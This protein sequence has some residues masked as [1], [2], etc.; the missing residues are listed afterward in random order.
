M[1]SRAVL[2]R[3]E[4]AAAAAAGSAGTSSPGIDREAEPLDR[5]ALARLGLVGAPAEQH[6]LVGLEHRRPGPASTSSG[7]APSSP[8]MCAIPIQSSAPGRTDRGT[9]RS[10]CRSK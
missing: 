7:S 10:A 5:L 2:E 8:S 4:R 3:A 9:L 6:D 1:R